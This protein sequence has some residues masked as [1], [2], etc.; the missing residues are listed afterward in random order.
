VAPDHRRPCPL[1]A[2]RLSGTGKGVEQNR[3][4]T[5]AR[6]AIRLPA[7]VARGRRL[8]RGLLPSSR[9]HSFAVQREGILGKT[10]TV[11]LPASVW[12]KLI[13]LRGD[14]ADADPVFVSRKIGADGKPRSLDTSMV[15]RSFTRRRGPRRSRNPYRPIGSATLTPLTPSTTARRFTLL[16]RRWGMPTSRPR[17]ATY[18][19]GQTIPVRD[20]CR[21]NR[22]GGSK[23]RKDT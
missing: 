19:P 18:T 12:T 7:L 15:N 5:L 17:A 14:A 6:L 13:A 11:L 22:R 2:G 21:C 3:K 20:S 10:R 9:R 1:P 23:N 8:A 16:R 4:E